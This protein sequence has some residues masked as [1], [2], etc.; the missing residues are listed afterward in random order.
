MELNLDESFKSCFEKY[1]VL[2]KKLLTF[3]FSRKIRKTAINAFIYALMPVQK[4]TKGKK[5]SNW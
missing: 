1:L 3:S 4:M 5:Y 2:A